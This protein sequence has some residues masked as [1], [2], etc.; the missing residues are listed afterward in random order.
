M[1]SDHILKEEL[2]EKL[3]YIN[4]VINK[5]GNVEGDQDGSFGCVVIEQFLES[6]KKANI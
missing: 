6:I 2:I 5:D 4:L 1:T 3:N